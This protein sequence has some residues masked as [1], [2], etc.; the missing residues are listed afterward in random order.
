MKTVLVLVL[1]LLLL[2]V[3]LPLGMGHMGDCPMCTA[4]K[5]LFALGLCAGILSLIALSVL[6][7]SSRFRLAPQSRYRFILSRSI[8]RPPR[9]A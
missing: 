9:V 4:A 1:V 3:G 5:N 2:A 8:Y 7:A 6:L